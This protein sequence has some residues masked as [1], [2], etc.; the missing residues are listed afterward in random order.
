[1]TWTI[2]LIASPFLLLS[3]FPSQVGL[4]SRH[5]YTAEEYTVETDDGYILRLHRI[6]GTPTKPKAPGKPVVYM[7]HGIGL[8]SD[9]YVLIGPGKDLGNLCN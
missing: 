3:L 4:V 2:K 1:M 7:Q 9:S 6:S 8:S 5:G